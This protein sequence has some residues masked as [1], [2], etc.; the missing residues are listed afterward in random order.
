VGHWI[1]IVHPDGTSEFYRFEDRDKM[2]CCE[3][4]PLINAMLAWELQQLEGSPTLP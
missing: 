1:I 3:A 4:S 2:W